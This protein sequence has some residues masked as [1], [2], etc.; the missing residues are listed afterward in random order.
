LEK[1]ERLIR[2]TFARNDKAIRNLDGLGDF[3]KRPIGAG[4]YRLWEAGMSRPAGSL[5]SVLVNSDSVAAA[6]AS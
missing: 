6:A 1:M 2:Q 4:C 3:F 5:C